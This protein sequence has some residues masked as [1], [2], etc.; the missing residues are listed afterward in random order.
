MQYLNGYYKLKK[1][2]NCMTKSFLFPETDSER[3]LPAPNENGLRRCFSPGSFAV[4]EWYHLLT[5]VNEWY[6][7][8]MER[9]RYL[10]IPRWCPRYGV[11][12][13]PSSEKQTMV[14]FSLGCALGR[15]RTYIA[16]LE[17]RSFIH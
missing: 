2:L 17:V 1:F 6:R 7:L 14:C 15:N 5:A 11:P 13:V 9:N 4:F 12:R 16:G 8:L 10:R 3:A